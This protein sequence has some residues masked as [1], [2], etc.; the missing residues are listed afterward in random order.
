MSKNAY[1]IVWEVLP[2]LME[3]QLDSG[4]IDSIKILFWD[5]ISTLF[6][7]NEDI[8]IQTQNNDEWVIESFSIVYN[9]NIW[10]KT[11]Y[12]ELK[13]IESLDNIDDNE[14]LVWE[15]LDIF[16][17]VLEHI[18]LIKTEIESRYTQ[19]VITQQSVIIDKE[20]E[21]KVVETIVDKY[22]IWDIDTI[23]D[24]YRIA[25]D[26][27]QFN[28]LNES[29]FVKI[30][31]NSNKKEI[32]EK[33]EILTNYCMDMDGN[34]E[35][36]WLDIQIERKIAHVSFFI[37]IDK[38]EWNTWTSY[39]PEEVNREDIIKEVYYNLDILISQLETIVKFTR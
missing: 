37:L 18:E 19:N 11:F 12:T 7:N 23:F 28:I 33:Y 1:D 26:M 35:R 29:H 36:D 16:D 25:F 39:L 14:L 20:L 15:I 8:S 6:G 13:Y 32:I 22:I 24:I 3:D 2:W 10:K 5:L 17:K 34:I 4:N 9:M 21:S 30:I 31:K 38:I 27:E